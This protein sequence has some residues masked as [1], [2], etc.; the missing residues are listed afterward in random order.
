MK[1]I[2]T[3]FLPVLL[4]FSCHFTLAQSEKEDK[5]QTI[6]KL[7]MSSLA[8][9]NINLNFERTI[10]NNMSINVGL[11]VPLNM[12]VRSI[13]S[14]YLRDSK[15]S[16][17]KGFGIVSELRFFSKK[18]KA[19]NG[20]Y[21]APYVHI[22]R[23]SLSNVGRSVSIEPSW[24]SNDATGIL[25]MQ[26]IKAHLVGVGG[27]LGKQWIVKNKIAIDCSGGIGI[28]STFISGTQFIPT[29]QHFGYLESRF[30]DVEFTPDY[31][32]SF[33]IW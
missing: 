28:N 12:K 6:V 3:L 31:R 33:K 15:P 16:V 17:A 11:N 7:N 30:N 27:V 4:L 23:Y 24:I 10:K 8:I 19:L 1:N 13:D 18:N 14:E 22:G 25:I 5:K 29:N 2:I 9:N 32:L 20:F 26:D 21:T